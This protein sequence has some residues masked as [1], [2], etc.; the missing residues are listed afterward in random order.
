MNTGKLNQLFMKCLLSSLT[1][2]AAVAE[3][4]PIR[5]GAVDG[6]EVAIG[7]EGPVQLTATKLEGYVYVE[8][9]AYVKEV[10]LHYRLGNRWESVPATY[11]ET[12]S[13]GL[14]K[15]TFSTPLAPLPLGVRVGHNYEIAFSYAVNGEVFGIGSNL[16]MSAGPRG[17]YPTHLGE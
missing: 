17:I 10:K 5:L 11:A 1:L 7:S 9:L 8:N 4:S 3:A 12:M 6:L 14:E 15:W 16:L 2:F 13:D